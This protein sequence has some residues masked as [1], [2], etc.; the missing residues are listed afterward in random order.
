[1]AVTPMPAISGILNNSARPIAPPKNSARSVAMA[2][3]SLT[4]HI[5]QTTGLGN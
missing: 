4:T 5:A 3:I 1:M 2:A